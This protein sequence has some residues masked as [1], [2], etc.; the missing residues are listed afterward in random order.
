MVLAP[1]RRA[2]R[3]P[4]SASGGQ[5]VDAILLQPLREI[6]QEQPK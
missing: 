2:W 3:T 4:R 6:A 5:D 1:R